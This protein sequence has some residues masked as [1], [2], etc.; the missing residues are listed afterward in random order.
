M[1]DTPKGAVRSFVERL[2][3][4]TERAM[5]AFDRPPEGDAFLRRLLRSFPGMAYRR[6]NDAGWTMEFV[7][8]GALALTGFEPRDLIENRVVSYRDLAHP[9]DH[10]TVEQAVRESILSGSGF[11]VAYR[12]HRV[13]GRERRVVEHGF[14]V[15]GV[16][17]SPEA[18]E[19]WITDVTEQRDLAERSANREDQFRALVEQSLAGVY[20]VREGRFRYANPRLADIFGYSVEELLSLP[21]IR[22]VVH[23][24]DHA[25][26]TENVRK[27]IDGE[28]DQLRY[29]FRVN[30]KDGQ[31]RVVEVHGRRIE[32]EDGPAVMGT[33]LDVTERKRHEHRYHEAQMM[34]ALGRLARGVAHDLNNFL[35]V[36][37]STAELAMLDRPQDTALADDLRE[38]VAAADR[39]AALSRQLARFGRGRSGPITPVSLGTLIRDLQPVLERVL[40]KDV[41]LKVA[42]E[43]NLPPVAVDPTHAD[44]VVMNLV[45]NARDAMPEGGSIDINVF[46]DP[47][48]ADGSAHSA[49]RVVLEVSDTGVGIPPETLK[50]I[51][52]P[53]FTTKGE[54][55]TGLG[56]A[57]VWRIVTDAG[58]TVDVT[59]TGGKG[60][61]FRICLPTAH[62]EGRP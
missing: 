49:A 24:D 27:R 4:T 31:E 21:S 50:H 42:I 44:E 20:L 37:K 32:I 52:E 1:A 11:Q 60:A 30:R 40:G 59:S 35:A 46:R 8:P 9:D 7:S 55:G 17:G 16:A 39:G 18:I 58:G 3:A 15:F 47:A 6:R 23:P 51:F 53:Y 5:H 28:V 45:L 2:A 12:I 19:G 33:L 29:E 22:E 34:A 54:E 62:E 61:T 56:L 48:A 14:P 13:D 26:V 36:I 43:P 10:E 38:V 41:A 25:L 57:N